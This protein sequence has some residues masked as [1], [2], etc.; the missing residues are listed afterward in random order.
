MKNPFSGEFTKTQLFGEN[1]DN[2]AKFG[3]KGHNG[4]D[5][6][7]PDG[8]DLLAPFA[9]KVV[10]VGWDATGYGLYMKIEN[11]KEGCILAHLKDNLLAINA[12]CTEG[13][14]IAHSDNTGNSTGPH[15]HFGYY[16]K[17]CDKNN[18]YSGYIDPEP[19]LPGY[20][21]TILVTIKDNEA[22]IRL[23]SFYQM[24][25]E[26][27][28]LPRDSDISEVKRVIRQ[29]NEDL[30]KALTETKEY[31][32][33]LDAANKKI[34]NM[35]VEIAHL[36]T[37]ITTNPQSPPVVTEVK[38]ITVRELLDKVIHWIKTIIIIE[39]EEKP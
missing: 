21:P 33:G 27:L 11:D 38:G 29:K 18:G 37:Q 35:T 28:G 14:L 26:L 34:G 13:Q 16:L 1:P 3:L 30:Q 25:C 4:L 12:D 10:E 7:L 22:N 5:W 17:P 36:K 9:G 20:E 8:T 19:Y 23:A 31:K 6:G 32:D 39:K 2:Y 24:V 15:L